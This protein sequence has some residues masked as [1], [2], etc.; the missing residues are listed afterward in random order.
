MRKR[1]NQVLGLQ[2][3]CSHHRPKGQWSQAA[4]QRAKVSSGNWITTSLKRQ[5]PV[6]TARKA[7]LEAC[8]RR[9]GTAELR[10]WVSLS[11]EGY[12]SPPVSGVQKNACRIHRESVNA[13]ATR[14][15]AAP[16]PRAADGGPVTPA[17]RHESRTAA[18]VTSGNRVASLWPRP[19]PRGLREGSPSLASPDHSAYPHGS[20]RWFGCC[21][22]GPK[23]QCLR[24]DRCLFL[25]L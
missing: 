21:R 15:T 25:S 14:A 11:G 6:R 18:R 8:C 23:P 16:S 4:G 1:P 20:T 22:N 9:R 5:L 2:P 12:S 19:L 24:Q 7:G 17:P 13:P 10:C 3:Q